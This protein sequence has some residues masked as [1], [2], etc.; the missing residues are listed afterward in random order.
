MQSN[1]AK[2][3]ADA[4]CDRDQVTA[5]LFS[6]PESLS[7]LAP[8]DEYLP[9]HGIFQLRDGSLGAVFEIELLQHEPMMEK[10][11]IA[12]V[13]SLGPWFSLP[14]NCTLQILHEQSA[15]AS[16]DSEIKRTSESFPDAHP[17]SRLLFDEKI[18]E[19]K[20]ACDEDGAM[21][22]YKRRT[23]LSLRYFI[24][25]HKTSIF[26]GWRKTGGDLL[27]RE[28]A[29]HVKVLRAF[30]HLLKDLQSNSKVTLR[31][32]AASDLL[33]VLRRFFNPKTY[34]KRSFAA[35]NPSASLAG[36]FLY[37]PPVLDFAGIERE[38]IKTR[39]LTL[40]TSPQFV[41]PGGMAYFTKIP[42]PFRL[43]LNVSFPSKMKVRRFFDLKAFFLQNSVSAKARMQQAEIQ[44]VQ[45]RLARDDRCVHLTFTVVIEGESDEALDERTR[46]LC[47]I[48]H[49]DLECEVIVE[50]DIG[51][52]LCLNSL[53]LWYTPDVDHSSQRAIR[54]LRSDAL[55]LLPVFDSFRGMK[56]PLALHLS[57]ERNLV[58]FSLLENETSNHTVILADSGSGKSALVIDWLLAAKRLKP[59]PLVFIIDKKSSYAMLAEFMEGDVTVFDRNRPMPFSPFRGAYDEEKIAFLTKLISSAVHLTSPSFALE[60]EHQTAISKALKLAYLKKLESRGLVYVDGK[61]RKQASSEEVELTMDDF[62][63]VLGSLND[64]KSESLRA[65]VDALL[66]KLRPFYGDGTYAG[67]FRG[68]GGAKGSAE[69]GAGSFYVYDLDALDTD[70]V[71]QTLMTMAVTQEIRRI[72][73]LP[74]NQG[75]TGFIVMEEFAMLGRSNPLF[76][77]FAI[78]F[79][80][81]MRKRGAWLIT[82]TPRP[83]NYFELEVGKAFWGVAD[84]YVFL[85]MSS[86]NVDYLAAKSSLLDEANREII[87]SLRTVNGEFAEVFYMN[88][89]KTVQGAF[90]NYQT[91]MGRW[92]A[93]TNA[94]A[95]READ[96]ALKAHASRW[97]ALRFLAE[98]YPKG[99]VPA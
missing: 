35:W 43:S 33:D 67:F 28:T 69:S 4:L 83:Q 55:N 58:P 17:V 74:E 47:S 3:I 81:T 49:N 66:A 25:S 20:A 75:R 44:E 9:A 64:G 15:I 68:N 27:D 37:A 90:R 93:P 11:V 76:R 24:K 39:T 80:E 23:L 95:A 61:L 87:R 46:A 98:T 45:E 22:P 78:D 41:Y 14:E 2:P 71:L 56:A 18:A 70:P 19:I 6:R 72:L 12:A 10:E 16:F 36:Q 40:K 79:A 21:R 92:L 52:G 57:R 85:Q 97:E 65:V 29:A 63:A 8:F 13:A 94:L 73:A 34:Y 89:K 53:P 42:F 91:P 96:R 88:K 59:E 1:L 62:V 54:I 86:D 32:L 51:L 84:N 30:R 26:G 5:S 82:L 50:D 7:S 31:P 38:G 60:S 77:D 48:F 99:H